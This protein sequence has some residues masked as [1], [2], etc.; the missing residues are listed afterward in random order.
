MTDN[1]TFLA[2]FSLNSSAVLF[3]LIPTSVLS[4]NLIMSLWNKEHTH[5]RIMLNSHSVFSVGWGRV[6][7]VE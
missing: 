6:Y 3:P 1:A 2:F 4:I 7:G 5:E